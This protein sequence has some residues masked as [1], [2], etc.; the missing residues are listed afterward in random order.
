M[1]DALR[2]DT[3]DAYIG[4]A[5]VKGRLEVSIRAALNEARP[6]AHVLLLAPP[7]AGKTTL[8]HIVA[9]ELGEPFTSV[10]LSPSL[11]PAAWVRTLAQCPGGVLH[12]DEVHRA[13]ERG[14]Q[15][16]LLTLL[17]DGIYTLPNGQQLE[18]PWLTVIASTTERHKVLPA[19]RDRFLVTP[20]FADYADD[21]L[22]KIGA[23]MAR[24]LGFELPDDVALAIGRAAGG[25]PR[26]VKRLVIAAND[27]RGAYGAMPSVDEVLELAQTSPDGLTFDHLSYLEQLKKSDGRAGLTSLASRLRESESS[28]MEIERLLLKLDL[29]MLT[30]RGRELTAAAWMRLRPAFERRGAA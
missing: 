13:S 22:G 5:S 16:D 8:A 28:I 7:G 15:E 18:F 14:V 10:T 24:M 21:E 26:S 1:S 4:Q 30:E 11:K 23:G 29:I 2:P 25:L 12:L 19:V 20:A 3:W 27:L 17:E 9:K 6:M